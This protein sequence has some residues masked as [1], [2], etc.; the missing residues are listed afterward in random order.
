LTLICGNL[1]GHLWKLFLKYIRFELIINCFSCNLLSNN[2]I[3][4]YLTLRKLL[5]QFDLLYES[6]A[7]DCNCSILL[8]NTSLNVM[9][10]ESFRSFTSFIIIIIIIFLIKPSGVR[11]SWVVKIQCFSSPKSSQKCPTGR[12]N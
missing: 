6:S 4:Q 9:I 5:N 10:V 3:G 11:S 7:I 1:W 2:S 12:L 8:S